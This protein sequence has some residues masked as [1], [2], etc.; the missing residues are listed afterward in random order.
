MIE[1]RWRNINPN[2]CDYQ[3]ARV[4]ALSSE[5]N[6]SRK[7]IDFLK[8]LLQET[9]NEREIVVQD[10]GDAERSLSSLL[11]PA[12]PVPEMIQ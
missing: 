4:E 6:N 2:W 3:E 7:Q 1:S 5:L 12:L 10:F 8:K 9:I 11:V